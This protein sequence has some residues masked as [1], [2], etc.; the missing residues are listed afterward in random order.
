M[1]TQLL[2]DNAKVMTKG[3]LIY[4][5]CYEYICL[6]GLNFIQTLKGLDILLHISHHVFGHAG[7][8][9]FFLAS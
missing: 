2:T 6:T 7:P 8:L 4:L 3:T 9:L 5:P 1:H